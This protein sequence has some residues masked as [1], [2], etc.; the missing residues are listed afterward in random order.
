MVCLD[1]SGNV[2]SLNQ[3]HVDEVSQTNQTFVVTNHY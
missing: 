1:H 3:R 2:E